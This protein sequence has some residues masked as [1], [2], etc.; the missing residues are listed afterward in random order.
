[1]FRLIGHGIVSETIK[2]DYRF[3]APNPH[4]VVEMRSLWRRYSLY[5]FER[6]LQ[7]R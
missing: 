4:L 6:S 1:M 3:V 7:N 2:A 5:N